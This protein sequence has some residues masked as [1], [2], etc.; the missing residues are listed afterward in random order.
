MTGSA[1][2]A[3]ELPQQL[4][5]G[6]GKHAS[7]DLQAVVVQRRAEDIEAAAGSA[8]LGS[9][10]PNTTVPGVHAPWRRHTSHTVPA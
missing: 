3:E 9:N 10:A 5:A 2:G 4:A 7:R 1:A 6:S 8:G